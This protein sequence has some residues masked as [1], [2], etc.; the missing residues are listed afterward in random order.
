MLAQGSPPPGEK[1]KELHYQDGEEMEGWMGGG[2]RERRT[3]DRGICLCMRRE[4]GER[5]PATRGF[6]LEEQKQRDT[7]PRAAHRIQYLQHLKDVKEYERRLVISLERNMRLLIQIA[8]QFHV[9]RSNYFYQWINQHFQEMKM[10]LF[11]S[12][13]LF[14]VM[15]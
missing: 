8:A 10:S 7:D 14:I 1:E 9:L 6:G 12:A 4:G 15:C 5:S 2:E 3:G 13:G 11:A